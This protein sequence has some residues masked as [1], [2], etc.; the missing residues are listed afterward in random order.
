MKV[1]IVCKEPN[2]D[3]I[4]ARM[5]ATLA[6]ETGWS[7]GRMPR[8]DVDLNY[9]YPYLDFTPV[10][11][12][13]AACFSHY[14]AHH[15]HKAHRWDVTAAKVDLRTTWAARYLP[16]LSTHGAS[17][18]VPVPL[19]HAAFMP[20][21]TPPE[22]FR[23]GVAGFSYHDNRKGEDLIRRLSR[24]F[25]TLDWRAIGRGW[26]IPTEHVAQAQLPAFYQSLA[27][28]V[29]ASRVEGVPYPPLEALATGV[30]VVIPRGVGLLDE[31]PDVPG[32]TRFDAGDYG[33][34][35]AAFAQALALVRSGEYDPDAL[36]AVTLGYTARAWAE[37]HERAF[38][39]LLNPPVIEA[40]PDWQGRAGVYYVAFGAPARRCADNAIQHWREHMPGVPAAV[41]GTEPIGTEDV[42]IQQPDIDIGGRIAKISID[43]LAPPD[44]TYVLYMDADTEVVAPIDFLFQALVDGWE[45]VICKNPARFHI[46]RE[47]KRPDNHDECDMTF[48]ALGGDELLQ[49]NGGVFGFRRN[50][51]TRR[52]FE[53]WRREW[54]RYGK[55][56]QLPLLRALYAEPLKTL[57]LGNEW[58][59][60]TRYDPPER[61]A[62]I[63]HYPMEARRYSGR[64]QGRLDS[65]EAWALVKRTEHEQKHRGKE[66]S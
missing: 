26:A 14:D 13:T 46:I 31:L 63:L 61:S 19:N 53:R 38:E 45:L 2:A 35:R 56:D 60:V 27:L 57:V 7:L 18:Q 43:A 22:G 40:L 32:I 64:T 51:R 65:P 10:D 20:P 16:G 25:N 29:C 54:E 44:W 47:A 4:I 17:I 59:T 5:A 58:N 9:F 30:P 33:S 3:H 62:G 41:V 1:H 66:S 34:L 42:F 28:F 11:T 36:R 55:R 15:Q 50:A 48:E 37:A 49:L 6:H 52:F 39:A 24:E 8:P 23:V 21:P 12:R